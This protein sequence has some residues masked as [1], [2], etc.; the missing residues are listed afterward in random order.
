MIHARW[1]INPIYSKS[2]GCIFQKHSYGYC[3]CKCTTEKHASVS[4][5]FPALFFFYFLVSLDEKVMNFV[6]V[7]IKQQYVL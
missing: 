7:E 1:A 5:S 4:E 2:Y 3:I 6:P